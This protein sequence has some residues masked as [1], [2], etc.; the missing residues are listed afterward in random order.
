[1]DTI[2]VITLS[3]A[4]ASTGLSLFFLTRM[5][6][7]GRTVDTARQRIGGNPPKRSWHRRGAL[8]EALQRL[9][10][11][12]SQAQKERSQLAGALQAAPLGIVITDDHGV[13]AFANQTAD[14]YIEIHQGEAITESRLKHAVEEA[15]LNRTAISTEIESPTPATRSLEIGVVP[16]D[17]GVESVGAVAYLRDLTEERRVN[18]MHRDFVA[19]V[20]HELRMPLS[21]L[22]ALCETIADNL[23]DAEVVQRLALRLGAESARLSS[24]VDK[25]LQL[26]QA[27]AFTTRAEAV[28]ASALTGS[29]ADLMH[30]G[31][32]ERGIELIVEPAPATAHVS[33]DE[34]QLRSM[35]VTLL[36]NAAK[37]SK[38]RADGAPPRIWLR[39]SIRE[40]SVIITVQDEGIGIAEHHID[41]IFE[42]FYKVDRD[43]DGIGLGL[44]IV[45]R[46][47]RSHGGDVAVASKPGEGT[48]FSVTLPLRQG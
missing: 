4:V 15:I 37:F 22:A 41:H 14:Q 28:Q 26:S 45:R 47:A 9:E 31:A 6:G 10:R 46:I 1:V 16:L 8:D 17:F 23:D 25:I 42:Q 33:G 40:D 12:T 20:N 30:E 13:V 19:N 38:P 39:T 3:I 18:A 32:T 44:S 2:T 36:D 21:A 43:R 5:R 35:L 24:L 27:E 11:S 29:A 34:R 48:I 7:L